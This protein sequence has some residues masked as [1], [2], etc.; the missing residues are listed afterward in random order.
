M[1]N[2][3]NIYYQLKTCPYKGMI[4]IVVVCKNVAGSTV[5][6]RIKIWVRS[7]YVGPIVTGTLKLYFD[8]SLCMVA[9]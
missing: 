8:R 7:D 1:T 9:I 5:L 3:V 4:L 6:G 2:F